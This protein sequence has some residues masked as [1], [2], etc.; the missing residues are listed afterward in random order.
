VLGKLTPV[1][2]NRP[3]GFLEQFRGKIEP[4]GGFEGLSRILV[5]LILSQKPLREKKRNELLQSG[6]EFEYTSKHAHRLANR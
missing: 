4:S 1:R 5:K 3:E 2:D 6:R